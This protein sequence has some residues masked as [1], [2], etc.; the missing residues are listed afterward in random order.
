MG[1]EK[2]VKTEALSKWYPNRLTIVD[3]P[4][5]VSIRFHGGMKHIDTLKPVSQQN[6][7]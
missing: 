5:N 6:F 2:Q 3:S 7:L 1:K 4:D